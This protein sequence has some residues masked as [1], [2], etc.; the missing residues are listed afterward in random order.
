MNRRRKDQADNN[1]DQS[2][3]SRGD[4]VSGGSD[5]QFDR[6]DPV[7]PDRAPSRVPARPASELAKIASRLNHSP[8]PNNSPKNSPNRPPQSS[9]PNSDLNN[10]DLDTAKNPTVAAA[11]QGHP[12]AIAAITRHVLKGRG[13]TL[14][15]RAIY[16]PRG[17][18][19]VLIAP[20]TPNRRICL[21]S[22]AQILKRFEIHR[23]VPAVWIQARL[24]GEERPQWSKK[25]LLHRWSPESAEMP[26]GLD[27]SYPAGIT[28][29]Q[30]PAEAPLA[31]GRRGLW[32][33]LGLAGLSLLFVSTLLGVMRGDSGFNPVSVLRPISRFISRQ[34]NAA[35]AGMQPR[36]E[37]AVPTDWSR[38]IPQIEPP[39][40]PAIVS[41]D[42]VLLAAVGDIVPGTNYPDDRLSP[43][44]DQLFAAT[45]ESLRNAD[46]TF[47]NFESVLTTAS[48][49]SKDISQ[50]N[51]FVF[52]APPGYA[53]L[54]QAVGFDVLNV[55]NNHS[56]DFGEVGLRDSY[57]FFNQVGIDLIGDPSTILVRSINGIDVAFLAF[58]PYAVHHSM[59]D[60]KRVRE[61]I[62]EAGTMADLVV[63]SMHAGAEGTEAQRVTGKT[64]MFFGENRGNP[65]EFAYAAIDAGA[66]L[67][68]GHGPHIL[69]GIELYKERLIVYSLGNFLSYRT[70][71]HDGDLQYSM[72]LKTELA[73]NGELIEAQIIPITLASEGIPRIDEQG[74]AIKK[75]R[76][77]T[78]Q[79][80]PNTPLQIAPDGQVLPVEAVP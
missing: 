47:G 11:E 75:V 67:I 65:R 43:Q 31:P 62:Q 26:I 35:I 20:T 2:W 53:A 32:L 79:D 12:K 59:N 34:A 3:D 55:A 23:F 41:V 70:L 69:R 39:P 51:T 61:V 77:L 17:L 64:E 57:Q 13:L 15:V 66:D 19:L 29:G 58:S 76:S 24:I 63:V 40:L 33:G 14:S 10:P 42:T 21:K 4:R 45:A 8:A 30:H 52:R 50:G 54:F 22:I 56:F 48:T 25:I 1:S 37:E 49:P 16:T 78:Q 7:D 46:L 6:F 72:I 44:P 36:L 74:K 18:H 38:L 5:E 60:L 28:P 27:G 80:F 9:A 73:T 68:L 71:S